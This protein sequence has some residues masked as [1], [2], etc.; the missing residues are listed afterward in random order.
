MIDRL[1]IKNLFL[2]MT[3]FI[4]FLKLIRFRENLSY[5]DK[6]INYDKYFREKYNFEN[7]ILFLE[8]V[9]N[10]NKNHY[11]MLKY[12]SFVMSV[13]ILFMLSI[14]YGI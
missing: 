5:Y 12:F 13:C 11:I 3:I 6:S 14:L 7:F 9:K 8:N 1:L 4:M 2:Y 10:D